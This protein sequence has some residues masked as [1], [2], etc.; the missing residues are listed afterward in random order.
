MKHSPALSLTSLL[1]VALSLPLSAQEPTP[2]HGLWVWKSP[3]VL[4][5]PRGP[6]TL[7][8]FCQSQLVN[9]IYISA[10]TL[11]DPAANKRFTRLIRLLHRSHIQVE[12]LLNSID[13]DE[14]GKAR[15]KLLNQVQEV[16]QFNRNHSGAQFDGI[17]LDIEPQQNP[18]NKGNGNLRFLPGLVDTYQ[19]VQ[20]LAV[21]ANLSVDAD[22][23]YK[24]LKADLTQRKSLLSALPRLTLMLYELSGPSD[25]ANLDQKI[26]KLQR[27][28]QKAIDV[29]YTGLNDPHL[30]QLS[31][32]LRV[33]DYAALLP[34]MLKT[35]D[36]THNQNPH[37]RGWAW[38]SY[39]DSLTPHTA[40][41]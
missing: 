37:Y 25:P 2:S 11:A 30:A 26:E 17:H 39:N 31:I 1:V 38:H 13:A 16:L 29:A 36:N 14:P 10:S 3:A 24:L 22:I 15:D 27:E 5:V 12:A 40:K 34:Q 9:E 23:Q 35:L 8:D 32:G 6:E 20:A 41:E 18:K 28:S 4:E 19:A 33:S 21:P 7:R